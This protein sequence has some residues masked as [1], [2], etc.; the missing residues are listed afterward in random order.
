MGDNLA[1]SGMLRTGAS[2]EQAS[3][4]GDECVVELTAVQ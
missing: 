1:L 2:V 4:D 3:L